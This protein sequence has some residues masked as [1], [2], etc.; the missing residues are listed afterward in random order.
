MK[1]AVKYK[2]GLIILIISSAI[3]LSIQI[4]FFKELVEQQNDVTSWNYLPL[5][6]PALIFTVSFLPLMYS[7][8]F[9]ESINK[10]TYLIKL[11]FF[12]FFC[13]IFLVIW[14]GLAQHFLI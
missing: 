1:W 2:L 6:I 12:W 4:L 8:W 13:L 7:S 9:K 3:V 14:V 5:A 10:A 11:F